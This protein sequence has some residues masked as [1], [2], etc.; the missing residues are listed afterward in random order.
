[1]WWVFI[2]KPAGGGVRG[3]GDG[4]RGDGGRG[5]W[6]V[7]PMEHVSSSFVYTAISSG[8]QSDHTC[9]DHHQMGQWFRELN[10]QGSIL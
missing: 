5:A 10:Q 2:G 8:L 3:L 9:T 6:Q 4:G 7:G 1:M